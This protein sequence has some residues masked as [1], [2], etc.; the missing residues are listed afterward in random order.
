MQRHHKTVHQGFLHEV[1]CPDCDK[2]CRG[3]GNLY[4]HRRNNHMDHTVTCDKCGVTR[5][6]KLALRNHKE[7]HH[8]LPKCLSCNITFEN[9]TKI[10]EHIQKEHL[11]KYCWEQ[12]FK[13]ISFS[14]YYNVCKHVSYRRLPFQLKYFCIDILCVLMKGSRTKNIRCEAGGGPGGRWGRRGWV[15]IL[16]AVSQSK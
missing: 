10:N 5:K 16:W 11:Q 9:E 2:M 12:C 6:S 8:P 15:T 13:Q 3:M 14:P 1:K 7:K 4:S